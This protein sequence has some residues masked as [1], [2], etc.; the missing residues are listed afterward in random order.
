MDITERR[1]AEE[2]RTLALEA[3]NMGAWEYQIG[4]SNLLCDAR[5]RTLFGASPDDF[6]DYEE[7]RKRMHPEDLH[8]IDEEMKRV[9]SG[10]NLG[11]Y[12]KRFRANWPDGTQ[13][14]I[15]SHGRVFFHGEGNARHAVRFAGVNLDITS[16]LAAEESSLEQHKY[17]GIGLLAGGIAHDFNNLLTV[18][19]GN[20]QA[21]LEEDP[22]CEW[23]SR[24]SR[25]RS[26]PLILPG[27]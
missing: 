25:R 15:E 20:A 9:L 2:Q 14:W 23:R 7:A 24:S 4:T 27:S 6:L 5:C 8:A 16:R 13:H 19:M 17:E 3:A 26:A 22:D 11:A 12:Q 1:Q 10:A 18:I 21:A